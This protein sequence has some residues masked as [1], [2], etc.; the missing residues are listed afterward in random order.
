MRPAACASHSEVRAS[1]KHHSA[2]VDVGGPDLLAVDAPAVAVAPGRGAQR[3][4]VGSG[5]GLAESLAPDHLAARDRRQVERAAP[6]VPCLMIVGP[7]QLTPMY[8]APR[9][10]WAPTSPRGP[11]S[12]P[13][14]RRR[15]RRTPPARPGTAGPCS[16][17]SRQN[18]WAAAEVGRV[19]GESPEEA[20]GH[21]LPHQ[22]AQLAAERGGGLAHA[23]V[24]D[25]YNIAIL[26]SIT[27]LARIRLDR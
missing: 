9:G 18:R 20:R 11:R 19:L 6:R 7:T 2:L 3:G 22:V 15:G 13:R 5:L 27:S 8:W 16:A 14:P 4:E 12:A 21:V 23:E 1:R 24:H 26:I 17:S 10:S 25:A